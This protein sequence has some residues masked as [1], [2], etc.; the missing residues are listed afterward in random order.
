MDQNLT[1]YRAFYA[2]ATHLNISIAAKEL[3]ISQPA[4]SKS[5]KKLED[6]LGTALFVRNSRGVKLTEEGQLLYD[7]VSKAFNN[8]ESGEE[9]IKR[10]KDL[11]IGQIKIGVST[12]LCKFVLLKY[13]Q[14]F[15]KDNPHIQITIMTQSSNETLE[16]LANNKIDI[17][18]IGTP[19]TMDKIDFYSLGKI[20][21][22]FVTSPSYLE[23][24]KLRNNGQINLETMDLMLLNKGNISRDY[25]DRFLSSKSL[26]LNN[27]IEISSMDLLIDFA[28]IG[29]GVSCVIKEFIENELQTGMLVEVPLDIPIPTRDLGFVYNTTSITSE[30]AKKFIEFYKNMQ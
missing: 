24:Y 4:I 9:Q 29:L 22:V 5:I 26:E 30:S 1:L 11:G 13:L 28:K 23:N 15:I 8:L 21:D 17:G 2:V 6:N 18:L 16:L 25:V 12:T 14:G 27:Y 10:I 19:E 20:H 7:Y 3:Y